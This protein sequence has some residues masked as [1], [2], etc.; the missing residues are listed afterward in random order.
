MDECYE[1]AL[2]VLAEN[3]SRLDGI[4]AALLENETLAYAAAGLPVNTA[5]GLPSSEPPPR[6]PPPPHA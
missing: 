6:L 4:A 1:V 5:P 2:A 3:R